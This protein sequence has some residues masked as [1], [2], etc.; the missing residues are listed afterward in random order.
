[1][2]TH[3][4]SI[5]LLL[6]SK[7]EQDAMKSR[8]TSSTPFLSLLYAKDKNLRLTQT[9]SFSTGMTNNRNMS[10]LTTKTSPEAKFL[11]ATNQASF[12]PPSPIL[13]PNVYKNKP[14]EFQSTG[15]RL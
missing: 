8:N 1:M 11:S 12:K 15:I 4:S 5:V 7:F 13:W 3:D 10:K 14:K 2:P 6:K 9:M